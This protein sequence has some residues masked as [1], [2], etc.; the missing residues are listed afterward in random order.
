MNFKN[1]IISGLAAQNNGNLMLSASPKINKL[2]GVRNSKPRKISDN[3]FLD[4]RKES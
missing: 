3:E 2:S 4:N 1:P